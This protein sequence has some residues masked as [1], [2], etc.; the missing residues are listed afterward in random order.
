MLHVLVRCRVRSSGEW[1]VRCSAIAT[2]KPSRAE[3]VR[4]PSASRVR[5]EREPSGLRVEREVS[6]ARVERSHAY[7][8]QARVTYVALSHLH[9]SNVTYYEL[10]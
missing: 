3:R 2:R 8:Y 4:E 6:R 1:I 5:V 9:V 10:C 7:H